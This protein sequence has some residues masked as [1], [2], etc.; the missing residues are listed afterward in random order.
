M[1]I[2]PGLCLKTIDMLTSLASGKVSTADSERNAIRTIKISGCEP[3]DYDNGNSLCGTTSDD[4]FSCYAPV[5]TND[6]SGNAEKIMKCDVAN[7]LRISSK[8][9]VCC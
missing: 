9:E 6:D 2:V 5:F 8:N 4:K 7:D 3:L 1:V